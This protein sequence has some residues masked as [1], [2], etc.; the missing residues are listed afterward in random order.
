MWGLIAPHIANKLIK[1]KLIMARRK[2]NNGMGAGT[3]I[4]L[5]LVALAAMLTLLQ[6]VFE[7]CFGI[8]LGIT[9][10]GQDMF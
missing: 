4:A 7:T 9:F 1:N 2:K 10:F 8:D 3:K 5:V 6:F